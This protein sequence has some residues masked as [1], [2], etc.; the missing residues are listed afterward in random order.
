MRS[1]L[2]GLLRAALYPL[3][4]KM[5]KRVIS[6]KLRILRREADLP[7]AARKAA[8][9]ARLGDVLEHAGAT[10]PYYRELFAATGFDPATV[11]KDARYLEDLPFLTKEILREQGR[12]LVS[13]ACLDRI[14]REQKTGSSTGP[15]AIIHYDQESLDWT[16]AQNILML[17]WGGKRRHDRE[18]HLSTRFAGTPPPEAL[19]FEA[20]KC[21][22][23]NRRNIYTDGFGDAA[24]ERLL[25]DLREAQA[26]VVQGHPSTL[27]ALAR[28][29]HAQGRDGRGLFEIF[30]STGEMITPAQRRLIEDTLHVRV[31]NRYGACEFGVMAQEPADGPQGELLVSDSLVWPE[32]FDPD[33]LVFTGLRNL[34]M[35]LIRYRMG[36]LGRLEERS[37]GWWLTELTGRVHDQ[38]AIN[39]QSYPTHYIQDI[40][41]R[42]GSIS[43]FQIPVRNNEALEFRLVAEAAGW[44]G[45][46][47][48]V[49]ENFPGVPLRRI[50]PEELVFTGARGKFSY[51]LREAS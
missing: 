23:L 7:F 14:V 3:A 31:S 47:A 28:R 11:R 25:N 34:A 35:P 32:R 41:D 40:F 22:V 45:I 8:A 20:R 13:E 4:E 29:L 18:A 33:E 38:V 49:R 26:R 42:C 30:V 6:P 17:E 2:S 1:V 15:A 50:R 37:N 10:V 27:F 5:Q 21:F 43:D 46:Q 44:E 51:L 19:R 12:R 39:G 36:D 48:A 9:L 16:A 24:Q